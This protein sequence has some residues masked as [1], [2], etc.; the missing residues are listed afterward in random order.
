ML[1]IPSTL[2]LFMNA[3]NT[4]EDSFRNEKESRHNLQSDNLTKSLKK[5]LQE[6]M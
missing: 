3:V 6:K 2:D 5:K 4:P 1:F